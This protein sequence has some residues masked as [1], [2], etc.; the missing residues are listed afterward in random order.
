MIRPTEGRIA[1][2]VRYYHDQH[3][4][5]LLKTSDDY[6]QLSAGKKLYNLSFDIHVATIWG[7][8]SKIIASLACLIGASLPV[9]GFIIW[10]NRKF[11]KKKKRFTDSFS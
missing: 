11:G 10:Y 4:G 2:M 5:K 6:N 3:S 1:D 8:P 9:T 7:L